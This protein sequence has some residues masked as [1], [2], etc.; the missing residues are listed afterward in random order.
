MK[1]AIQMFNLAA[2]GDWDNISS[3]EQLYELL[4]SLKSAGYD[5]LE[6]CG[7]MLNGDWLDLE[8]LKQ[9]MDA[10]G[11]ETCAM[12]FHIQSRESL[13]EDC[14][15][16][17]RQCRV[18]GSPYLILASTTPQM[19]GIEPDAQEEKDPFGKAPVCFAPEKIDAWIQETN[20]VLDVMKEVCHKAGI[21]VLYHNHADEM[22]KGSD[23]RYFFDAI[24]PDGKE[25][26]VYW[27]AKGLDGKVSTALQYVRE[28][29]EAVQLI[30]I[31]D[32]LNGS[33]FP[34]EM[35]GWGKGTYPIQSEIDCAKELGLSYVVSENDAPKNFGTTGL[36]DAI[37]TAAYA[38]EKLVL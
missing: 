31:K 25:I 28:Q 21:R 17:V 26:D 2:G 7:F 18:L 24:A 15:K 22:R 12:H 36:E 29:K 30:H 1:L 38:A 19:F 27:V 6:W 23:G 34:N 10:L 3:M 33:V 32:G 11:L 14:E 9:N 4:E 20:A 35:C 16:A 37:Q 8:L 5:G 13:R